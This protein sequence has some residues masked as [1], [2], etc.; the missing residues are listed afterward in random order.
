MKVHL[1]KMNV[2]VIHECKCGYSSPHIND[3][4]YTRIY[5]FKILV[6]KFQQQQ[7]KTVMCFPSLLSDRF[8]HPFLL[9]MNNNK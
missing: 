9:Y 1:Y 2:S 4:I 3:S 5:I 8:L 7:K 6:Y